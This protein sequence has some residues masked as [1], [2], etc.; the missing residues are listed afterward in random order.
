[1]RLRAASAAMWSLGDAIARQGVQFVAGVVLARIISPTEFG[2]VA[3]LYLFTGIAA[4][5]VE[6]GFSYS[7]I[8][9]KINSIED[10]STVFWFNAAMGAFAA[11]GLIFA[12]PWVADFYGYPVL[13]PLAYAFSA[14]IFISSLG[15]IHSTLLSRELNFRLQM[16]ISGSA[17]VISAVASIIM[18]LIGFG[19]WALVAQVLLS[20]IIITALLWISH[21]WRPAFVF[22]IGSVKNL[23]GFGG[24][25]FAASLL[26]TIYSK[27]YTVVIGKYFGV[28]DLAQYG[29][30]DWTKQIVVGPLGSMMSKVAL[31]VLS[32]TQG[33]RERLF[34]GV[35]L[36]V[37][38][39]MMINVPL[40]VGLIV[41]AKPLVGFLY[42]EQWAASAPLLQ[43]LCAGSILLPLHV[44]NLNALLALGRSDLFFRLE[45]AKK[46]FGVGS[47]LV[48]SAWGL[49]GIAF[50]SIFFSL[51][52]FIVNSY[53]TYRYLQ[54]GP[55][56][57]FE[58][59]FDL[60][61]YSSIA[62]IC[63]DI[64]LNSHSFGVAVDLAARAFGFAVLVIGMIGLRRPRALR[65]FVQLLPVSMGRFVIF[66][67][68][69][70]FCLRG[71]GGGGGQ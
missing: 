63:V 54:Y 5:F 42:G 70:Q 53:Y 19:V 55:I 64:V 7:L 10:E 60:L 12:A 13:I 28:S 43:I 22:S 38:G 71:E 65:A 47:V 41:V 34:R 45:V 56:R 21:S 20:S 17:S 25:L 49:K 40:M 36:A 50:A 51:F 37:Q 8:Q 48:G 15:A 4:V 66:R 61:L 14:N 29:R 26:D 1:M 6:G 2:V 57:Q 18:A 44:I 31:P 33:D 58:E 39:A 27:L 3:L 59:F 67:K 11:A 62:G 32:V 30:A 69:S 46:I 16:M 23:F 35:R 52:S 68:I 9:S 24:Y